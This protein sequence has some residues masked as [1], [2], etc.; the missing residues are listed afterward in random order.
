M[1]SSK[2]DMTNFLN[3]ES[4]PFKIKDGD[5]IFGPI[6]NLQANNKIRLWKVKITLYNQNDIEMSITKSLINKIKNNEKNSYYTTIKKITYNMD[7]KDAIQ[8]ILSDVINEGKNIGKK[9]ETNILQQSLIIARGY[10]LKK[11]RAGFI[12][13]LNSINDSNTTNNI[14]FPMAVNNYSDH[15]K[16]VIYPYALQPKLDGIRALIFKDKQTNEL[17]IISR[18]H[19]I[20]YGFEHILDELKNLDLLNDKSK[21]IYLDGELYNHDYSLQEISGIVRKEVSDDKKKLYFYMF[22]IFDTNNSSLNFKQRMDI[23]KEIKEI[24]NNNFQYIKILETTICNTEIEAEDLLSKYLDLK[25]EG[26][27][28]K[29]L[30][31]EY[32]FSFN[33]EKRSN[34]YLKRK[35][36]YDEEFKIINY[37]MD[38]NGC[39]IFIMVTEDGL[40]FKSVPMWTVEKRQSI[41]KKEFNKYFLN[42]MATIRYDD[43]S[44]DN[45]PVRSR[46]ITVR[47]YE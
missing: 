7:N 20:I 12:I 22:D 10:Y 45:I 26:V 1:A 30:D 6:Y 3:F 23:M 14:P 40:E 28:Y 9:N 33:K 21:S 24:K 35:P 32:E 31:R 44:K 11:L 19:K 41:T 43:L 17:K 38:K 4:F 8:D 36:F 13:D 37:E 16:K 5:I 34:Y 39:I 27:I 25:Y 46:F 2:L 18:R 47:D 15:Y 42:K 29:P